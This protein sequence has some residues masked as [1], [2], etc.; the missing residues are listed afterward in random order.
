MQEIVVQS[1]NLLDDVKDDRQRQL[2]LSVIS[3][4][5]PQLKKVQAGD[6]SSQDILDT[7]DGLSFALEEVLG[8]AAGTILGL[9]NAAAKGLGGALEGATNGLK[10]GLEKGDLLGGLVN[11]LTGLVS[12]GVN[13]IANGAGEGF[14][15]GLGALLQG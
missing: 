13:S 15:H 8:W 7:V 9:G 6:S 12:G 1:H 10:N 4:I 2:I 5:E 11:G 3:K 14:S